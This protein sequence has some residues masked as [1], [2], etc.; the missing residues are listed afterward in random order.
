M[1]PYNKFMQEELAR[2]KAANPSMDHK[3]AFKAAAAN[4]RAHAHVLATDACM[5]TLAPAIPTVAEGQGDEVSALQTGLVVV[6]LL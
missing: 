2:L 1:S 3:A 5:L 6:R 4:V